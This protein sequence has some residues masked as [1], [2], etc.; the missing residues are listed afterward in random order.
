MIPT[1]D[2]EIEALG[3][4]RLKIL[5]LFCVL[6][7]TSAAPLTVEQ[8]VESG[9]LL[10]ILK[11]LCRF[12]RNS[13]MQQTILYLLHLCLRI[14]EIASPLLNRFGMADFIIV[15]ATEEWAKPHAFRNSFSGMLV[16]LTSALIRSEAIAPVEEFLSQHS[17][18]QSFCD[19]LYTNY[20]DEIE[21]SSEDDD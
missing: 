8:V 7:E 19:T 11:M 21:A 2:G 9:C 3:V 1:T 15:K 17:P 5:E 13:I 6:L 16:E 12:P 14:K 10:V 18:W 20:L 4:L